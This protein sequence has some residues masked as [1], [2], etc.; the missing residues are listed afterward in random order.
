MI[1]HIDCNSFFASC[2]VASRPELRG[3]PVVVANC[4]EAGGGIIL[5]LTDEAKKLGL[6]RGNPV[7]QVKRLLEESHVVMFPV[8]HQKYR[9]I[10]R[11]IMRSVIEQDVVQDFAQYSIDEF[12][13]SLPID[14]ESEVRKYVGQVKKL[15]MDK[16]GVP[17]SCGCSQTYT[18]AKVATWYAKH[19]AGYG[20]VCVLSERNR[21]KALGKLP[22]NDVWGIGRSYVRFLEDNRIA[23]ALDFYQMSE[24]YVKHTMKTGGWRTWQELHG[25]AAISIEKESVQ[26]SMMHSLTF[27]YMTDD[28]RRLREMLADFASRLAFKLREQHSVCGSVTVF[29]RT[30]RHR[31]D[32]P[33][34]SSSDSRKLSSPT[35]DTRVILG[36]ALQVLDNIYRPKYMYKKMGIVLADIVPAD[37]VQL[38]LFD[39]RDAR[40]SDSLM[41]VVD[42]INRKYGSE[43]VHSAL[44]GKPDAVSG[45]DD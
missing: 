17:V 18:L 5:A 35:Q 44:S 27:T 16:T 4:N 29:I 11:Q 42:E 14:D 6:K 38:D 12:F 30:N 10:S 7:F 39:R 22:V 40:K 8:N 28:K 24:V 33:Q 43:T 37:G 34:Y 26:K 23:T 41:K 13:G 32:L 36:T 45:A 31:L 21:E 3:K 19:F 25:T 15:I 1:V 9:D 2:E 20:G